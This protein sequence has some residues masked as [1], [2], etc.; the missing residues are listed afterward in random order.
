[1]NCGCE[2]SHNYISLIIKKLLKKQRSHLIQTSSPGKEF[3]CRVFRNI[4][5]RI[6]S[7]IFKF[8]SCLFYS[9]G[10]FSATAT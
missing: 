1:M 5:D 6:E 9:I 3:M 2:S 4:P 10:I 7:C 8:F